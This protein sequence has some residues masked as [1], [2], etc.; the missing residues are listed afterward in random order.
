MVLGPPSDSL[1]EQSL[2]AMLS[3]SDEPLAT[4]LVASVLGLSPPLA[5]EVVVRAGLSPEAPSRGQAGAAARLWETLQEVVTIVAHDAFAPV[6][7]YDGSAP[8]GFAP[9]PFQSLAGPRA[10]PAASM[11]HAVAMGLG[12]V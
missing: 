1:D 6:V 10:A 5:A 2:A 7:Y 9:F 4:R 3:S 8:V 12:R 11:R